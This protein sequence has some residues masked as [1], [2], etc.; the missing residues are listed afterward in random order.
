MYERFVWIEKMTKE[1]DDMKKKRRL[2]Q[3]VLV[4]MLAFY[5]VGMVIGILTVYF[6][7]RNTYLA[8]K[9][10]MIER[11]L[12]RVN[13]TLME[14]P[15]MRWFFEYSKQH[16]QE[17][18]QEMTTDELAI[19][20]ELSTRLVE[21]EENEIINS[22]SDEEKLAFAKDI[23]GHIKFVLNNERSLFDYGGLWLI[24]INE[25]DQGFVY[26]EADLLD[27]GSDVIEKGDELGDRWDI[28]LS[29][30][31]AIERLRS[32][33]GTKVE[34][35]IAPSDWEE[36]GSYY[37][38]YLPIAFDGRVYAAIG[39]DYNWDQF[40]SQLIGQLWLMAGI[41]S[42]G[43]ASAIILMLWRI[44]RVAMQPLSGVQKTVRKYMKDKDSKDAQQQLE[45]IKVKNEI[46]VL[47]DDVSALVCEIDSYTGSIKALTT[48]VM[49]AL[50]RTI[51]AKDKYTNGHSFRV[52]VYSKMLAKE[53]GMSGKEQQDIYYMGL[54]HD[55]GKIGIPNV[56]INKTSKLTD[57]EYEKI[58]MHPVYGYEILSEIQSMPEL[59]IGARYHH[60]RIDG[61]GYP[62]GLKGDEIPF[63]ARII[64][65][66]DSYDTMTSNRS[67]RKYLAQDV[68]R[69]EIENN[70]GT[71]FDEAPAR[72][73]LKI[74][75]ADKNY[76]LHE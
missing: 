29:G 62:D 44:N 57:E 8:A 17:I 32:G 43:M 34:F 4:I 53:L 38:A 2:Q 27:D 21:G 69:A 14:W 72:A 12:K 46:G 61:K 39:L 28:E 51:D 25:D 26:Y 16:A 56:I 42:V 15:G 59:S 7:S 30:H 23:Y 50:A 9:N 13:Q 66:A 10:D 36:D 5:A 22:F 19:M 1:D 3:Q 67:Y 49:E 73:M 75:D 35:E 64:A 24:D 65:V 74:I 58:K 54:L 33:D 71:Q 40:H 20:D 18:K 47:A 48:E 70:I 76:M 68:V 6:S 63:M 41:L 55:I 11:D 37:I 60:E 52:A 31:P 45:K